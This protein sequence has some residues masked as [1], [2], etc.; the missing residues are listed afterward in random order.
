MVGAAYL[1]GIALCGLLIWLMAGGDGAVAREHAE[2]Q[3]RIVAHVAAGDPECEYPGQLRFTINN[4]SDWTIGDT[5]LE[6]EVSRRG[7]ARTLTSGFYETDKILAPGEIHSFC[8]HAPQIIRLRDS[9]IPV[10]ELKYSVRSVT[11]SR[12]E[13]S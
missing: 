6:I 9:L 13:P 12:R 5:R 10:S 11:V 7:Y 2:Q 3:A 4:E 1:S 8:E